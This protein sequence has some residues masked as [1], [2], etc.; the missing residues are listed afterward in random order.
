MR[1]DSLASHLVIQ[2]AARLFDC[3]RDA[4]DILQ[5]HMILCCVLPIMCCAVIDAR[6]QTDVYSNGAYV[7]SMGR[8]CVRGVGKGVEK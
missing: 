2:F 1:V 8:M 7:G 4:F 6:P 3:G 5:R